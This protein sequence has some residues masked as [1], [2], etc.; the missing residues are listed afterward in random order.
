M[1]LSILRVPGKY[2]E[3]FS[4]NEL[5]P[6]HTFE[7]W[8]RMV[9]EYRKHKGKLGSHMLAEDKAQL[10]FFMPSKSLGCLSCCLSLHGSL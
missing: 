5:N 6:R 2:N 8:M 9:L 7:A 3:F 1:K 10:L 4:D